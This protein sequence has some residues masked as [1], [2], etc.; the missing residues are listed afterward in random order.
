MKNID[1]I[2]KIIETIGKTWPLVLV[3]VL[4]VVLIVKWKTIWG[5][6][7][8]V[9]VKRI[10]T[11]KTEFEFDNNE[12]SNEKVD[13]QDTKTAASENTEDEV[14]KRNKDTFYDCFIS[15]KDDNLAEATRIYEEIQKNSEQP[16]HFQNELIFLYYKF[17]SGFTDIIDIFKEKLNDN[18]LGDSDK[19]QVNFYL[20]LCYKDSGNIEKTINQFNNAIDLAQNEE[21][22]SDCSFQI[23]M[24][25]KEDKAYEKSISVLVDR[26]SKLDSDKS[27]AWLYRVLSNIYKDLDNSLMRLSCL[28]KSIELLPNDTNTLFDIAFDYAASGYEDSSIVYYLNLLRFK[29]KHA[30]ALNNIG[31][32]FKTKEMLF[33][34]IEYYKK[35]MEQDNTLAVGNLCFQYINAGF[36]EEALELIDKYK[37]HENLEQ[38][39]I[40]AQDEIMN[41]DR[42][43]SDKMKKLRENGESI[44]SFLKKYS[45]SIFKNKSTLNYSSK[46]WTD[47][48]KHEISVSIKE[49]NILIKWAQENKFL[50]D[51]D[52]F[53]IEGKLDI[54]GCEVTYAYPET[55]SPSLYSRKLDSTE[56]K[57]FRNIKRFNGYCVLDLTN[58]VIEILYK[59]DSDNHFKQIRTKPNA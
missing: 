7:G 26:I 32:G 42:L 35:A 57:P 13:I 20:G 34:S 27:K 36:K 16:K 2:I 15:L 58:G 19:Y 41:T 22:L 6:F 30:N 44:S 24:V 21:Q 55:I 12:K 9:K 59:K 50:D 14:E 43:K 4:T 18:N 28:E 38:M 48:E 5:A 29:P 11:G 17:L 47:E 37:N 10:K 33:E 39:V 51:K 49:G 40:K 56:N 45:E 25:Y 3:I 8:N 54:Y 1:D 31:S 53:L 23:S 46:E 52:E